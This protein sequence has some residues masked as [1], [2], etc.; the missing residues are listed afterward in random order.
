LGFGAHR[1]TAA[2]V[3]LAAGAGVRFGGP[4]HKLLAEFRGRPLVVWAVE[5]A[6]EA[7]LDETLVIT[8]AVDLSGLELP[9][10]VRLVRAERWA[11][12]QAH[13]LQAARAA[14]EAAG[15]D[16]M[17]LGLGDQPLIPPEAWRA[18]AASSSP[19]AVATYG[20][21][22]RNPVRLARPVWP[23]L[24]VD[25]DIGARAV[26]LSRPELVEEVA[27]TG[28]PADVDTEEDLGRWS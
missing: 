26:M 20:G 19:I 16:A 15:H 24:P 1:V 7:G 28:E 12:G 25:G 8:G 27:C 3:V 10:G 5:A 21:R 2:A 4:V 17:V 13:S 11:E 6:A 14:V 22:R 18:V 23:L 9:E